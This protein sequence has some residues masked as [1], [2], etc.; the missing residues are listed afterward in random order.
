MTTVS[1]SHII[2]IYV[3]QVEE[4]AQLSVQVGDE[5]SVG[6]CA[7]IAR[8]IAANSDHGDWQA[9]AFQV[10]A[11]MPVRSPAAHIP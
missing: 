8:F 5:L 2:C 4:V 3:C 10:I 11:L 6:N 1:P 9:H 7:A